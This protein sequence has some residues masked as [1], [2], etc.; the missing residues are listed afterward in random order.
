MTD[1]GEQAANGCDEPG[2]D[3]QQ[4]REWKDVVQLNCSLA[5]EA[6]EMATLS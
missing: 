1:D 6:K 4:G 5:E 3:G 2:A